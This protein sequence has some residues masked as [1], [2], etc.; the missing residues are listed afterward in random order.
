[1]TN[2]NRI[3]MSHVHQELR[4]PTL[5]LETM[6][7]YSL[8]VHCRTFVLPSFR[9]TLNFVHVY[10]VL[11]IVSDL[12]LFGRVCMSPHGPERTLKEVVHGLD[13][14]TL[15]LRQTEEDE[16]DTKVGEHSV[17]QEYAVAHFGDH[18]GCRT[19]DAI[20]HDPV[21]EEAHGHTYGSLAWWVRIQSEKVKEDD[22]RF[23]SE[24]SQQPQRSKLLNGRMTN[25]RRTGR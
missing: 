11:N 5:L 2:V 20:I 1:M 15:H 12:F 22:S 4:R 7:L 9:L 6:L 25:R 19:S 14:T 3:L 10:H 16:D 24:R 8:D 21:D 13:G 23:S 17:E 18:I